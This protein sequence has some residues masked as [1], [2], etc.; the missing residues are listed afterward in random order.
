MEDA[1][2]DTAALMRRTRV[3][4]LQPDHVNEL[5]DFHEKRAEGE[6][7]VSDSAILNLPYKKL[8]KTGAAAKPTARVSSR[9]QESVLRRMTRVL[10]SKTWPAFARQVFKQDSSGCCGS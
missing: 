6:N 7:S 9:R 10:R 1:G 8:R 4:G 5:S 2:A 3:S